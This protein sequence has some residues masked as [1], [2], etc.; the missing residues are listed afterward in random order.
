ME[1]KK[2]YKV[3]RFQ[4]E[5]HWQSGRRAMICSSGKPDLAVGSPPE[6]KG[7]PGLWT[8]EDLFVASLNVC[9]LMTFIAFAQHEKLDFAGYASDAE[10]A[11]ENV[12]GKYRFSEITLHPHID[13]R[14][15]E[16]VERARE[17][18]EDAHKGC[19]ITN[20]ISTVVKLFPQFRVV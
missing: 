18:L 2:S 9:T 17:I 16:D 6:F 1:A 15:P 14:S 5:V 4:S 13:V 11:L 20:S 3:F 19:F 12:D 8:P 7:E 10:G